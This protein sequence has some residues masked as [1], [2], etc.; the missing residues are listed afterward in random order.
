MR[1]YYFGPKRVEATGQWRRMHSKELH[2]LY[3]SNITRVIKSR[4]PRWAG[5]VTRM[6]ERRIQGFGIKT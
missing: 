5:H 6:W 1:R 4:R 3:S 2:A